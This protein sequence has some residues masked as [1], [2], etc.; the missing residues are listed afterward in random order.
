MT[1]WALTID[2]DGNLKANQM[3]ETLYTSREKAE[4]AKAKLKLEKYQN[5][6]ITAIRVY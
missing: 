6:W 3:V 4:K 2:Y 5:A 1:V